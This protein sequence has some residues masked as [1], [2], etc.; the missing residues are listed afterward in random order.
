MLILFLNKVYVACAQKN[1]LNEKLFSYF[2]TKV[3]VMCAQKNRL[4]EKL[5][6]LFLNNGICCVWLKEPSQ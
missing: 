3:Y 1:R 2:T 4:N 6:F 5:F